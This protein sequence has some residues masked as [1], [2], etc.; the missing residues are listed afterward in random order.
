MSE[1]RIPGLRYVDVV[2]IGARNMQNFQLLQGRG[3]DAQA[4]A[5]QA[6]P[7]QHRV[8]GS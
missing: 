7:V 5:A 2:Q 1:D 6:L 8:G 3:Q 4:G